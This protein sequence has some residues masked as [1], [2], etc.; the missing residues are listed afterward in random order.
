MAAF[1]ASATMFGKIDIEDALAGVVFTASAFVTNGIAS[2]SMLG[3]DLAASVFT[4]QGTS[5]DLAFLLS[6]AA[7][8]MAYATNRVNESRNKNYQLDTDLV[9]IAKGSA[10]VE[11]YLALGTL[12]I[13]LFTGLNILGAQDIVVGSAAIGLVVVAVEAAGYY[14][15]SYLG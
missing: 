15:I 14:V 10:T 5:I 8:A 11:T 6:L 13:V 1:A 4:V 9:E 7:L 3:Y 12:I 2:I